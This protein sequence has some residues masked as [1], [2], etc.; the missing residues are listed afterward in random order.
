M[1]ESTRTRKSF[2]LGL[3]EWL[4]KRE[5]LPTRVPSTLVRSVA[6][7]EG[8]RRKRPKH[9][10]ISEEQLWYAHELTDNEEVV[11]RGAV[12]L[13]APPALR[14]FGGYHLPHI[15]ADELAWCDGP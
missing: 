10:S 7:R 3:H 9:F 8:L 4:K 2:M 12:V 13:L 1:R 5:T 15:L 11:E 14:L 6:P